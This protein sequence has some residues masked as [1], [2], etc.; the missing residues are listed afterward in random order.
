MG[1][2]NFGWG[3]LTERGVWWVGLGVESFEV[4][5]DRVCGGEQRRG[6]D[7]VCRIC[8]VAVGDVA[9]DGRN[10]EVGCGATRWATGCGSRS[11]IGIF[12]LDGLVVYDTLEAGHD[13][14]STAC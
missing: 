9:V 3:H 2:K 13:P 8:D 14:L 1:C 11:I 10:L 6:V 5:D 4:S 12:I 7:C